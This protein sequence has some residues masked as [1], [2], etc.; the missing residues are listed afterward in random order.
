V[1]TTPPK[2]NPCLLLTVKTDK[3]TQI[4][5]LNNQKVNKIRFW[6]SQNSVRF[7]SDFPTIFPVFLP[8]SYAQRAGGNCGTAR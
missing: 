3:N 1:E 6:R 5:Y 2:H 7:E 8:L 4:K